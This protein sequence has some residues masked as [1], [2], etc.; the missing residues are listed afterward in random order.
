MSRMK[1]FLYA[2]GVVGTGFFFYAFATQTVLERNLQS[3]SEWENLKVLPEDITKDSLMGLM[4]SYTKSLGVRCDYCHS[5]R[6]DNP[7]KLN[8][9]DD[10][11]MSKLI[12]RG[13]IDMTEQINEQF[14]RPHYPD[15]KPE[16]VQDVSCVTCHRGNPNPKKYLEGVGSLFSK[17]QAK[18]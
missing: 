10:A 1:T 14:F 6:E 12:A 4:K 15:P 2:I 13:M 11:K 16:R 17:E 8:F 7:E 3:Q 9:P 18:D 5:P